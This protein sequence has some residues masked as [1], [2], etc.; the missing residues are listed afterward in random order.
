ETP[1]LRPGA[2]PSSYR[3]NRK[4]REQWKQAVKDG[5]AEQLRVREHMEREMAEHV[6]GVD[7]ADKT[8]PRP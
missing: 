4:K 6:S 8:E 7:E 2:M 5:D 1:Q 3:F